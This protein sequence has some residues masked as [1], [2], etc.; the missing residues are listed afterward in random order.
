MRQLLPFMAAAALLLAGCANRPPAS[1]PDAVAEYQQNNDPIEPTNRVFYR[2]N[3][4]I[5]TV[6]LRPAAVAYRAV[7]P[8]VVRRP[9]HNVL[10]NMGS[11]VLLVNDMAQGKPRRAGDTF[12]R[13]LINTTAGVGGLFDVAADWGY[14]AHASDFGVTLGVWGLPDGPFLFL[15]VL[16]PSSPRDIVGYG[17]DTA[18]DPFLWPPNGS[19]FNTLRISR[20]VVGGLDAREQ[21]IDPVDQIKRDALDPYATFR[22][23]YRQQR[24]SEISA[25]RNDD[26]RTV[27]AWFP[28]PA[29]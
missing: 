22:S 5:D 24:T 26:R 15:P 20:T 10:A 27:P 8:G 11:P 18:M 21:L 2:I 12:M 13:M 28:Q 29:R 19:G 25:S 4:G 1:D 14:P 9:I 3:N 17:V 7:V 16:G 6:I 23:L